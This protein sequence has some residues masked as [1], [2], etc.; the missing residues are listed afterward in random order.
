MVETDLIK[1][2][3]E[4]LPVKVYAERP[5]KTPD[6]FVIVEKTAGGETNQIE[7]PTIAIQSHAKSLVEA[8]KL[9]EMVKA[10]MKHAPKLTHVG[11]A[12]LQTD[13]NFTDATMKEYRYQAVYNLSYH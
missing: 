5:A 8:A 6:Q 3:G 11:M 4:M 7:Y 13:Y 12:R 10:A 9:N 1:F 2:L